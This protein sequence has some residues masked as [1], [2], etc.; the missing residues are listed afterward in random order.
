MEEN[1]IINNPEQ[2]PQASSKMKIQ[3]TKEN[4]MKDKKWVVY[5]SRYW[6]LYVLLLLPM[7]YLLVFKYAPMAYVQIAFKDY[8]FTESVWALPF[9]KNHGMGH[10]IKAFHNR[11][12]WYSV[13]N[14]LMLNL[15]DLVLGFPAPIIFALILNELCFKRFKKVV[16]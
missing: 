14:T 9:T 16:R 2:A 12:F 3:L 6:Q 13:R 11:D 1:K 8:K 7:I 5:L 15:L 4:K 10:F